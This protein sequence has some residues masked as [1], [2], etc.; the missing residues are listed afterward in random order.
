MSNIIL[1]TPQPTP[2]VASQARL[3]KIPKVTKD[4]TA[5]RLIGNAVLVKTTAQYSQSKTSGG[6]LLPISDDIEKKYQL[7]EVL[8]VGPD[9]KIV[10]VGDIVMFQ[11]ATMF[12]VPN[13]I[14][15]TECYVVAETPVSIQLVLPNDPSTIDGEGGIATE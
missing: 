14:E 4:G 12:R 5:P 9:C 3:M 1:P 13:G 2:L 10:Q 6:I 8:G 15:P 7:G 11:K